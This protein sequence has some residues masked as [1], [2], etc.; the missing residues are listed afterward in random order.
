MKRSVFKRIKS[1][2]LGN[3]LQAPATPHHLSDAAPGW[4]EKVSVLLSNGAISEALSICEAQLKRNPDD[5]PLVGDF[6]LQLAE[7][8]L[9]LESDRFL[10]LVCEVVSSSDI[11]FR[12]GEVL[13][14]IYYS[15]IQE[16]WAIEKLERAFDCWRKALKLA[17]DRLSLIMRLG[18]MLMVTGQIAEAK[19]QFSDY[20]T[21]RDRKRRDRQLDEF[22]VKTLSCIPNGIGHITLLD[23]YVKMRELGLTPKNDALILLPPEGGVNRAFLDYW[24]Q[25][26]LQIVDHPDTVKIFAPFTELTDENINVFCLIDGKISLAY[27]AIAEVERRWNESGRGPLLRLSDEHRERGWA[28]LSEAGIQ[29]GNWFV[30]LH[31]RESGYTGEGDVPPNN[32]RNSRIETY[33]KA[34]ERITSAGGWVIRLGDSSMTRLSHMDRVL[35]YAHSSL[36]SD[37]MDIFLCAENKFYLGTSSGPCMIPPCFGK[38]CALANYELLAGRPFYFGNFYLPKLL[39]DVQRRRLMTFRETLEGKT[40]YCFHSNFFTAAGLEFVHNTPDEIAGMVSEMMEA[41]QGTLAYSDEEE[42]LNIRFNE[43]GISLD[44]T[45][46]TNSRIGRD[47]LKKYRH[48]LDA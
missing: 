4:S 8:S 31:V 30:T 44:A 25:W 40:A 1:L 2:F 16:N 3:G 48:L 18:S 39:F 38:K 11:L 15:Y 34:I 43:L 12:R 5:W 14:K 10:G 28:K 17:P 22:H 36:K 46:G 41:M 6:G 27:H 42:A 32:H 21:I 47:F 33:T 37:W 29:R 20:V 23:Y 7:G 19:K 45:Y 9:W 13:E 26:D 24:K 35:D